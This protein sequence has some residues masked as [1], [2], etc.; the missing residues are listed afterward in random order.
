MTSGWER[1]SYRLGS[2]AIGVVG[3]VAL[4]KGLAGAAHL[5]QTEISISADEAAG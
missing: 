3:T 1:V 4:L 5:F 2:M